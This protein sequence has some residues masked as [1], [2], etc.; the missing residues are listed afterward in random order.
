MYYFLVVSLEREKWGYSDG[1]DSYLL[2]YGFPLTC[3]HM[4]IFDSDTA[5]FLGLLDSE[6]EGIINT[7]NVGNVYTSRYGV[8]S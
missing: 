1:H 7:R 5:A 2:R 6:G 4:R 3:V 8:T